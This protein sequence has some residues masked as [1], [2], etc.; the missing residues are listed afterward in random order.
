MIG[1]GM[2]EAFN[3]LAMTGVKRVLREPDAVPL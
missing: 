2:S 3:L 1:P